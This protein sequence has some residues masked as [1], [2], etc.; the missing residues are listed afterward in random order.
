MK[1]V[2]L[3]V[4][5]EQF[6]KDMAAIGRIRAERVAHRPGQRMV[7]QQ[8]RQAAGWKQAEIP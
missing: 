2:L 8:R 1:Y 5:T 6:T 4:E 3:F 7:R